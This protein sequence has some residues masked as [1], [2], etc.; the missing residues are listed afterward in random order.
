MSVVNCTTKSRGLSM[1]ELNL[2]KK[3]SLKLSKHLDTLYHET[4]NS[5]YA[6]QSFRVSSCSTFWT[7][8]YCP[9]CGKYHQMHTTG[10]KHRL[11]PTCAARA[12]RVTAMQALECMEV[13]NPA[14]MS[15]L[16][17]TVQ[18]V[19]GDL[20]SHNIDSQLEAWSR[21]RHIREF[22][23]R[24]SG[25]A[26]TIEI[27]P[28]LDGTL[29]HPH[30]HAIL[31]HDDLGALASGAW[32]SNAWKDCMCLDYNP[33]V[34][35]RPI[36]N[37]ETSVF[38]VSKYVSK[39]SRVYDGT[40]R[41]LDNVRYIGDAMYNRQLRTYGGEWLKAR[42]RLKMLHVE[43]MED[44]DI[45]EYGTMADTKCATCKTEMTQVSLYW[46]GLTYMIDDIPA[47]GLQVFGGEED[48]IWN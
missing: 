6:A 22:Q 9:T 29:Y 7:G 38:E 46:A 20:L 40:S 48:E 19:T 45:S 12:S 8:M 3:Q 24:V 32:W 30:I 25:W 36:T 33:I 13:I 14:G 2:S 11:C 37:R 34:D 44:D 1:A 4:G 31:I 43:Q 23:R 47:T 42:R 35:I 41:E 28:A 18:N 15:L 26:R 5:V 16:T 27:V 10:C 39:L 17:L 21:L